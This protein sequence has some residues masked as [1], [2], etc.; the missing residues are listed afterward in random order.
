M[1]NLAVCSY[2]HGRHAWCPSLKAALGI[3][4][5]T[6][7]WV[8]AAV[9]QSTENALHGLREVVHSGEKHLPARS[10]P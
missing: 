7:K 6:V 1:S 10:A 2:L 5:P 3:Q 4:V 8:V 9:S